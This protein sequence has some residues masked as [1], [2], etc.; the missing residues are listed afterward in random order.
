MCPSQLGDGDL[1]PLGPHT[2]F[3]NISLMATSQF[4]AMVLQPQYAQ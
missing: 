3:K 1:H 2:T 4:E